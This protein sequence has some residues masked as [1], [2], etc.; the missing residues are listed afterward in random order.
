MMSRA[1]VF[2][3][4]LFVG[5]VVFA[6]TVFYLHGRIVE[7]EGP[8]PVHERFGLYDYPAIVEALGANGTTVVSEVRQSGT[9]AHEYARTIVEK[10]EELI[11]TG[12]A[13][14]DITVVGF[15]KGGS[16]AIF[17]SYF[18][19]HPEVNFVFI[20]AC[21]DWISAAPDLTVSG[22]IFSIYEESDALAGSCA[23]LASRNENLSSFTELVTSTGKEHGAF[24]LPRDDWVEPLLAWIEGGEDD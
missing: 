21:A 14:E 24:Y 7:D 3:C 9:K 20:A 2:V 23:S 6:G 1:L 12:A 19:G 8:R 15:S 22:N 13:P 4:L 17:T 18:L 11:E 10:F 16:I 5:E